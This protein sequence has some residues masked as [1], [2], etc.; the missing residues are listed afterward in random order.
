[1]VFLVTSSEEP[2]CPVCGSRM[3][4]KD[5]VRRIRKKAGGIREEYRIERKNVPLMPVGRCTVYCRISGCLL[6][7]MKRN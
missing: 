6:S 4:N 5:W 1:M 2:C 3:V 7:T